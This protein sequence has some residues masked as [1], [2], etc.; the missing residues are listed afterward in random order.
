MNTTGDIDV[1]ILVLM[2]YQF[3]LIIEKERH[4]LAVVS[5]LVLMDYQFRLD[6]WNATASLAMFPSLF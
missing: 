5:I 4:A 6:M 1:S 2:D 3:R